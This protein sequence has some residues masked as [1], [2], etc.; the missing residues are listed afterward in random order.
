LK[1][2]STGSDIFS[3]ESPLSIL[4]APRL[5][6]HV[7]DEEVLAIEFADKHPSPSASLTSLPCVTINASAGCKTQVS[8]SVKMSR[9][10]RCSWTAVMSPS[11]AT[12]RTFSATMLVG[13]PTSEKYTLLPENSTSRPWST[14][15]PLGWGNSDLFR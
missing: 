9:L 11:A 5:S 4:Y 7:T 10:P 2:G 3:I 6:I 1:S 15:P 8:S 14:E 12:K 13:N